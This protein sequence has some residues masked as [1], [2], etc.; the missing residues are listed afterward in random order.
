M[1]QLQLV[2]PESIKTSAAKEKTVLY[3][4][5]KICNTGCNTY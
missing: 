2:Q 1:Q 3:K 5:K 4:K